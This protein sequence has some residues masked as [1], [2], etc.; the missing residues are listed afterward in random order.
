[1]I[2]S[3]L[4]SIAEETALNDRD[5]IDAAGPADNEN[6]DAETTESDDRKLGFGHRA[7][8][9]DP[10]ASYTFTPDVVRP[11]PVRQRLRWR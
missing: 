6:Q 10:N 3:R 1:M 2:C 9:P 11:L 7:H 4:G 8:Q 5:R